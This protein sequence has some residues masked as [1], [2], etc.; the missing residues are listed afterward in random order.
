MK[1]SNFCTENYRSSSKIESPKGFSFI[2]KTSYSNFKKYQSDSI[3]NDN[4][5]YSSVNNTFKKFNEKNKS[6]PIL[7]KK[8]KYSLDFEKIAQ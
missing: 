8:K 6:I 2:N 3:Q 5:N 4:K 1:K 7:K